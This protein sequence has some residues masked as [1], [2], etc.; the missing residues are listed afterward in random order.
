MTQFKI[1]LNALPRDLTE[2][3]FFLIVGFTVGSIGLI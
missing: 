1:I 3:S 2:F